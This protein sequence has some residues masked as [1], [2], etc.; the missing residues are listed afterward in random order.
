M[1]IQIRELRK[2]SIEKLYVVNIRRIHTGQNHWLF[3][4]FAWNNNK[5]SKF[6]CYDNPGQKLYFFSLCDLTP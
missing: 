4:E 1:R 3:V 6:I 5:A 2:K